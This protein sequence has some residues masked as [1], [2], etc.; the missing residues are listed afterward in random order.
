MII[1]HASSQGKYGFSNSIFRNHNWTIQSWFYF[2]LWL[3]LIF[4]AIPIYL[5]RSISISVSLVI[6]VA[7][8]ILALSKPFAGLVVLISAQPFVYLFKRLQ[9]AQNGSLAEF[10]NPISLLPQVIIVCL[11]FHIVLE[12]FAHNRIRQPHFIQI[13]VCMLI[14]LYIIGVFYSPSLIAGIFGMRAIV[15]PMMM[16]FIG[17]SYLNSLSRLKFIVAVMAILSVIAGLYGLRQVVLGFY[18]YE[19]RWAIDFAGGRNISWFLFGGGQAYLRIFSIASTPYEFATMSMLTIFLL[20]LHFYPLKLK[21]NLIRFII[22]CAIIAISLFSTAI[23][24]AWFGC[25]GGSLVI[26]LLQNTRNFYELLVKG[27][28]RIILLS[29]F[30]PLLLA[31][32]IVQSQGFGNALTERVESLANPL[33]A[34]QMQS[35]YERWAVAI[36]VAKDHP[37]GIGT[38]S[39][40]YTA[41]RFGNDEALVSDS[42]YFQALIEIGWLGMGTVFTLFIT[43]ILYFYRSYYRLKSPYLKH[44]SLIMIGICIS[45]ALR[46]FT[47]PVLAGQVATSWFWLLLGAGTN[48]KFMVI[49]DVH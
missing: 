21:S 31:F 36:E 25:L 43:T 15:F 47:M 27:S 29:M 34:R 40:G 32:A 24:G 2:E 7:G 10:N 20:L 22:S 13:I 26:I 23:R 42:T 17:R 35:R 28:V 46:G 30:V 37:F 5:P 1:S 9:Y 18:P 49:E 45:F 48:I 3:I 44:F 11:L 4:T 38:G 19:Y 39:T 12:V 6:L 8:A 33:Q 41:R 16:F 14:T